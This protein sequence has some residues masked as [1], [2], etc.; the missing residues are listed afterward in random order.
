MMN[1]MRFAS[2][3]VKNKVQRRLLTNVPTKEK[4]RTGNQENIKRNEKNLLICTYWRYSSMRV[5]ALITFPEVIANERSKL[6]HSSEPARRRLWKH[7]CACLDNQVLLII[8][9]ATQMTLFI[10]TSS[11]K[12]RRGNA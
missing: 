5:G 2:D 6:R 7:C 3:N 8:F 9:V 1:Q 4:K 10:N 12:V 11:A